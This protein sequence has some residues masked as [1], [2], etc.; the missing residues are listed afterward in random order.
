VL[1]T[2]S[3]LVLL[4]LP[5]VI[6]GDVAGLEIVHPMAI[7]MVGGLVTT[8]LLSLFMLPALYLRFGAAAQPDAEFQIDPIHHWAGVES[9]AVHGDGE[10]V[11]ESERAPERQDD[12]PREEQPA[13]AGSALPTED[14]DSAS[15]GR[16]SE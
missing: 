14:G 8:T 9:E 3:A 13:G 12:G 7:V 6:M 2:A 16:S 5:F 15:P 1:T 4:L 10:V 11:G